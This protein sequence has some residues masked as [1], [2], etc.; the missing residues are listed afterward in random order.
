MRGYSRTD[1]RVYEI[2]PTSKMI[3][4]STVAKTGRL[5]QISGSCIALRLRRGRRGVIRLAARR[6]LGRSGRRG[7]TVGDRYCHAVAQ[8]EL[9]GGDDDVVRREALQHFDAPVASLADVDLDAGDL[10][11]GDAEHV[12]LVALRHDRLLRDDERLLLVA[13]DEAHAGEHA[14]AQ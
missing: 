6:R 4:D 5:M 14:G 2:S 11:V 1:S 10:A 13:R 9:A 7:R 3:S 12:L 8:L